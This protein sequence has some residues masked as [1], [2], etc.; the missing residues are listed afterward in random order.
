LYG[1]FHL[2]YLFGVQLSA[3]LAV[4]KASGPKDSG[5][6][7]PS[8]IAFDRS[9]NV[10]LDCFTLLFCSLVYSTWHLKVMPLSVYNVCKVSFIY[11]KAHLL[12]L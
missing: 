4:R 7:A 1:V 11:L 12:S 8:C 3:Y 6:E 5:K 10:Y 2:S 9:I